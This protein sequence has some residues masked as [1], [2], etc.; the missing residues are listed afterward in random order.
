MNTCIFDLDG[1][2]LPMP[3]QELFLDTYFKV[4]AAKFAP[5]G[6]DPGKLTKAVWTGTKAM[7]DND[8]TMTN[9]QRFW[10]TFEAILGEE[11][12]QLEPLFDEFYRKQQG[13]LP[14]IKRGVNRTL[15]WKSD[16]G[17]LRGCI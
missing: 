17:Q 14:Q 3:D 9:E 2:L 15:L 8:G 11:G 1:T 16:G 12:K 6:Y 7:L 10:S 5:H 13:H 4:L